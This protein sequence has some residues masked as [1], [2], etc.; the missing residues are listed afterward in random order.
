MPR[1]PAHIR[2]NNI[3][4]DTRRL[5]ENAIKVLATIKFANNSITREEIIRET[6]LDKTTMERQIRLLLAYDLIKNNTRFPIFPQIGYRVH[7][8]INKHSQIIK[9]LRENGYQDPASQRTREMLDGYYP[10]GLALEGYGRETNRGRWYPPDVPVNEDLEYRQET[11]DLMQKWK[12]EIKPYQPKEYSPE[13]VR[14]RR[15]KYQWLSDRLSDIYQIRR[16]VIR[17]GEMNEVTWNTKGSSTTR[18]FYTPATH[19]ITLGG[20]FSV[21]TFL[22]EWYHAKGGDEVDAVLFSVNLFK[23]VYP[24]LYSKTVGEGHTIVARGSEPYHM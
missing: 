10:V 24:V 23:R 3:V 18:S 2:G 7:T 4:G 11:M 20:L 22:H 8:D 17:V 13:N 1:Q 16:P 5:N 6:S 19:T 12:T 15:K 21:T 14:I 9:I